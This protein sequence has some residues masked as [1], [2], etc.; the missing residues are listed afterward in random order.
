VPQTIEHCEPGTFR[1]GELGATQAQLRQA[2]RRPPVG[3]G[4]PRGLAHH[5]ATAL[6]EESD[7]AL[8]GR[9]WASEPPRHHEVERPAELWSARQL[10]GSPAQDGRAIG[11][12]E[13]PQRLF[14]KVTPPTLGVEKRP[15]RCRPGK[16]E[17][18][19]GDTCPRAQVEERPGEP[20]P[21]RDG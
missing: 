17:G 13:L 3:A 2:I 21:D 4:L 12:L 10:L 11:D 7:G 14:E 15:G 19:T 9:G 8:R 20:R 1:A 6:A 5:E 16:E 18:E